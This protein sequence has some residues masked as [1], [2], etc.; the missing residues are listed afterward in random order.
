MCVCVFIY[1]LKENSITEIRFDVK[2]LEI[3]Q[4]QFQ[5]LFLLTFYTVV[6]HGTYF[7][8]FIS[9]SCAVEYEL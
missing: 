8:Y 3:K 4:I 9:T 7:V 2:Y 6:L 5:I 1:L